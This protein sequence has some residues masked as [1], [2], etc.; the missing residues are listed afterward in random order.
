MNFSFTSGLTL[1]TLTQYNS[2]SRTTSENAILQWNIQPARVFY[3]VWNDGLTLNPN[4]LQGQQ[5]VT[6]NTVVVKLV[7]GF[8]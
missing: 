7:W 3:L 6:G 5:T 1:S 2:I 4:L 8:Y